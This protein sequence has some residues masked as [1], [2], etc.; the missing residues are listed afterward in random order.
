MKEK[1]ENKLMH[2]HIHKFKNSEK[3]KQINSDSLISL[4]SFVIKCILSNLI[5]KSAR[6]API[7][8]REDLIHAHLYIIFWFYLVEAVKM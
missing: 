5:H 8:M 7:F 4:T 3:I 1:S 6:S 2:I